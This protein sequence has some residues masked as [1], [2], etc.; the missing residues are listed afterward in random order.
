[1]VLATESV[2]GPAGDHVD[3]IAH[4]EDAQVCRVD[5]TVRTVGEPCCRHGPQD[6]HVAQSAASLLEV[7][8][9][10]VGA[11]PHPG[12]PCSHRVE[13]LR[14]APPGI[15]APVLGDRRAGRGDEVLLPRKVAEVEQSDRRGQ[16]GAGHLAALAQGPDRMVDLDPGVPHGIPEP[17]GE[18]VDV[19][20]AH[21]P[22]LME[23]DEV[24]ITQWSGVAPGD[25]SHSR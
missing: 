25:A 7:R 2:A 22:A 16:V 3:G 14:Q 23:Q 4:V 5:L 24:V 21:C 9:D 12:M 17:I 18:A 10:E 13:H 19:L 1:M 8:L 20:L 6:G 11:V 15:G